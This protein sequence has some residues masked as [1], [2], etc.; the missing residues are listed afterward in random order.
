MAYIEAYP[1]LSWMQAGRPT[2]VTV[3][4]LTEAL[5]HRMG[6][7]VVHSLNPW[8][9]AQERVRAGGEDAL[10]TQPTPVRREYGL[11]GAERIMSIHYTLFASRENPR[12]DAPQAV[13]D[14]G[15]LQ[16]FVPGQ[17]RGRQRAERRRARC[18][19][20]GPGTHGECPPDTRLAST[21]EAR[22]LT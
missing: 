18:G 20:G 1:P 21:A 11:I 7:D 17:L 13:R 5:Q 22:W 9:R 15:D 4:I 12:F 10:I 14:I 19:G 16:P 8:K 3:T 2:G 6:L